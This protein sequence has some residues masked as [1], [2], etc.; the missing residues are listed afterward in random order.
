MH[1]KEHV[2]FFVF[3]EL[4]V[5]I[6]IHYIYIYIYIR[7]LDTHTY[8]SIQ[9]LSLYIYIYLQLPVSISTSLYSM[10]VCTHTK[11]LV[12]VEW[13]GI[14]SVEALRFRFN[15]DEAPPLS[16]GSPVPICHGR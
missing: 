14:D 5:Y 1:H 12:A 16:P 11:A 9:Y 13:I 2:T 7:L 8:I 3:M 15:T 6:Y 10:L 4:C